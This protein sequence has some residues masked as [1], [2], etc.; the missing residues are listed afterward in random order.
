MALEPLPWS[1]SSMSTFTSCPKKYYHLKIAKDVQDTTGEAALWGDRVHKALEARLRDKVPLPEEFEQYKA[2]AD[3]IE[4]GSGDMYVEQ[5]LAITKDMEPCDWESEL[6]WCRGIVDVLHLN[7]TTARVLDHKTGKRKSDS[8]Q[9]ALFALLVFYH[10]P[11]IETC[12]TM[13]AWLKSEQKDVAVY[14]RKDIPELWAMFANDIAA[15][16]WA[17]E[18]DKWIPRTSGLCNGWCPVTSCHFCVPKK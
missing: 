4:S 1:F 17:F 8:K 18:N 15:Y 11:Q 5:Q 6:A 13:F 9:L 16:N 3:R 12:K 10:Y 2:Y 14:T 7:G